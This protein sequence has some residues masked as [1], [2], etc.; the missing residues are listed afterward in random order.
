MDN[1][2]SHTGLTREP[3]N[4]GKLVS[5][6]VVGTAVPMASQ[7]GSGS[8]A[9]RG[10]GRRRGRFQKAKRMSPRRLPRPRRFNTTQWLAAR[11]LA[12]AAQG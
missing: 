9:R 10:W 2:A 6:T 3:W 11:G 4:K 5:E 8:N 12:A 7:I 1:T